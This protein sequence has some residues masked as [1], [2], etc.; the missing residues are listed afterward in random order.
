MYI[1]NVYVGIEIVHSLIKLEFD[2]ETTCN[3]N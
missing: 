1:I 3:I 2:F